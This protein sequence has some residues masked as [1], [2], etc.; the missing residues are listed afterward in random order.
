MSL[1]LLYLVF[2]RLCGW[3]VLLGRSSGSENAGLLVLRHVWGS[4]TGRRLLTCENDCGSHPR[5]GSI[6]GL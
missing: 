3:L 5:A 1:G 6:G 4:K 2:I